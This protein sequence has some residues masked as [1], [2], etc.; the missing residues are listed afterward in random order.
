MLKPINGNYRIGNSD[1]FIL[2]ACEY[3]ESFLNSVLNLQ[4]F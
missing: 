4:L 3:V 1:T 2:E